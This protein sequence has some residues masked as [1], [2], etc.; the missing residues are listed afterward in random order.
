MFL[1]FRCVL[2]FIFFFLD[3]IGIHNVVELGELLFQ[4]LLAFDQVGLVRISLN[5]VLDFVE[6]LL[7]FLVVHLYICQY[8]IVI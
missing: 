4:L 2:L 5:V 8:F 3:R 1:H 7:D 6:F